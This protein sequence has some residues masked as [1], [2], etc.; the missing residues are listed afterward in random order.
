MEKEKISENEKLKFQF[1][2]LKKEFEEL[3]E[4]ISKGFNKVFINNKSDIYNYIARE[5]KNECDIQTFLDFLY[6]KK[7]INRKEFSEHR[8]NSRLF[9]S[10]KDE[11]NNVYKF[12]KYFQDLENNFNIDALENPSKFASVTNLFFQKDRFLYKREKMLKEG[13]KEDSE[14]IKNLDEHLKEFDE[15]IKKTGDFDKK[16]IK[17]E[18]YFLKKDEA[19][20]IYN[21]YSEN[22]AEILERIRELPLVE[23]KFHLEPENKSLYYESIS[24]YWF[25]NFNA[26]ICMLSIFIESFL[27]EIWYYKKRKHYDGELSDLINDCCKNEFISELEKKYLQQLREF[28]RNNYIHSN[29][30]KIILEV[31][32]P[33]YLVDLTGKE[34]PKP[35]YTTAER[36]PTLRSIVK[37]D[38]DKERAKKLII[39]IVKIIESITTK[40]YEFQHKKEDKK[41]EKLKDEN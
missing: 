6:D 12:A 10:F 40:N 37:T 21:S 5:I 25:G 1:E 33:V 23:N 4:E 31:V 16:K 8:G 15:L 35:T 9:Q 2:N 22:K 29:W 34:K 39:E 27:K 24:N 11:N 3:K 38:I 18:E 28:I 20:R 7:I 17:N 30:H 19:E 41:L 14:E 36:L 26:S 13:Y 32:V